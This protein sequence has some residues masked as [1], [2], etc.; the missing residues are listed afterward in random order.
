MK[1]V[2]LAAIVFSMAGLAKADGYY[3]EPPSEEKFPQLPPQKA[4]RAEVDK[5]FKPT[6]KANLVK[7]EV[8][9]ITMPPMVFKARV[10]EKFR[11]G[12]ALF[13][14]SGNYAGAHVD[15]GWIPPFADDLSL[16]VGVGGAYILDR[17]T[18]DEYQLTRLYGRAWV[19]YS[20]RFAKFEVPVG[21]FHDRAIRMWKNTYRVTGATVGLYR[22]KW[23]LMGDFGYNAVSEGFTPK[24]ETFA[25]HLTRRFWN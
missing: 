6:L 23:G 2:L 17:R 15:L 7:H 19:T 12:V 21:V 16:N 25:V 20:L 8:P 24:G 10:P 14:A 5:K 9:K 22:G 4:M 18:S 11:S 13:G 1:K 3:V